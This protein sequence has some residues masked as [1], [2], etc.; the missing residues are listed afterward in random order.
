MQL[1]WLEQ[2]KVRLDCVIP[3]RYRN[4]PDLL[5]LARDQR[6]NWHAD[7]E[8][9]TLRDLYQQS[10]L[11]FL[12]LIDAVANNSIVEAMASGLPVV[13]TDVGG[14]ADYVP[15]AAGELCPP[16]DVFSHARA[17]LSWL[18][19]RKRLENAAGVSRAFAKEHLDWGDIA[20]H[21]YTDFKSLSLWKI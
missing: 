7:I 1:V 18:G 11:L 17:I 16:D 3:H 15:K 4:H 6:V 9:E 19:N 12:P 21:L 2:P 5:R 20:K 8:P 13:T 10:T 14:V